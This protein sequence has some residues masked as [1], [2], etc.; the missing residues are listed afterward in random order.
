M[1]R[2]KFPQTRCRAGVARCDITPPVG[3]YHRMWGAAAHDRSTGVH[4]PLEA[5]LLWLEAS[6]GDPASVRILVSLDHCL[7]DQS[8]SVL[9]RSTIADAAGVSMAQVILTVTHTH[10]AGRITRTR[11]DFPGGDLIGPYLDEVTR[12]LGVLAREARSSVVPATIMYGTGRCSLAGERDFHDVEHGHAVCGWN[13]AGFADDTVI[14]IRVENEAHQ[15]LATLVNYACH[16]TTLAWKNTL[17]SPDYV[18]ALRETVEREAGGIC[19]FLQGASADLG[20]REGFV[21]ETEIADRNGRQLAYS[22]LSA[23]TALPAAGTAFQYTGPVVSGAII[24]TW[25][26]DALSAAEQSASEVWDW[27]TVT[28]DLPYRHDM[29]NKAETQAALECWLAEEAAAREQGDLQRASDCRAR[30]EQQNRQLVRL[31]ELPEGKTFPLQATIGLLGDAIWIFLPGEIYQVLQTTLRTRF[32]EQPIV[33]TTLANDWSPGYI[34]PAT[35]FGLGI[36]QETIAATSPGS[37]ELLI[38]GV[39]R[40][41]GKIA[42]PQAR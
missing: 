12:Q 10:G 11:A 24:G 42:K 18:G 17:I 15:T 6:S 35:K 22:A 39:S 7:L 31:Q 19:L 28:V 34:P 26:H 8:D 21:G 38:E 23:L 4:R 27:R 30:V 3:M 20:P 41:L 37:L 40:E 36:Y 16:P 32:P 29:S 33:I 5:S 25:Q 2:V 1:N 13:P 9:M 14:A